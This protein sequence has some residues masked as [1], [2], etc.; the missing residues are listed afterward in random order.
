M[1]QDE[2]ADAREAK[3]RKKVARDKSDDR[4]AR[5]EHAASLLRQ[6]MDIVH[7]CLEPTAETT[8]VAQALC[9][10]AWAVTEAVDG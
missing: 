1:T 2:M 3:L 9:D 7:G 10:A 5:L 8:R 4:K 6:A